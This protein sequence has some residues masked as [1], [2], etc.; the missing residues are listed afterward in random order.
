MKV[1]ELI[2]RLE[3]LDEELEVGMVYY[4]SDEGRCCVDVNEVVVETIGHYL[5][6]S[7]HVELL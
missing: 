6:N 3:K 2:A 5:D 7:A 1:R 4:D